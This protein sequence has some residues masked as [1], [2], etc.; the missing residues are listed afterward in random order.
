MVWE[1]NQKNVFEFEY[2]HMSTLHN[3]MCHNSRSAHLYLNRLY[4]FGLVWIFECVVE[5]VPHDIWLFFVST[6]L[7]LLFYILY[8][9]VRWRA[10]QLNV[11][12]RKK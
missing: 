4:S 3:T 8:R 7:C 2:G 10:V 11:K 12:M 9:C 1:K 5:I 6:L